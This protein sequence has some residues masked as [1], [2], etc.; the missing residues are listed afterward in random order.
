MFKISAKC[1][2]KICTGDREGRFERSSSL[3]APTAPQIIQEEEPKWHF[4]RC[5]SLKAPDQP[6]KPPEGDA[7][8]FAGPDS[9]RRIAGRSFFG[10]QVAGA[11]SS[12]GDSSALGR[13]G[14]R[15]P[16]DSSAIWLSVG[17]AATRRIF[18]FGERTLLSIPVCLIRTES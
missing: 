3:Q 6:P 9:T 1:R 13:D 7:R 17:A 15:L 5:Q 14:A 2:S 4:G 11:C 12:P 16:G 18:G 10:R 8:R